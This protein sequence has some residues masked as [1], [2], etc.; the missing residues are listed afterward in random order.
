MTCITINHGNAIFSLQISSWWVH[1]HWREL[2]HIVWA[3]KWCDKNKTRIPK[4]LSVGLR[5]WKHISHE[6]Q[7]IDIWFNRQKLTAARLAAQPYW[8]T[9]SLTTAFCDIFRLHLVRKSHLINA[10]MSLIPK[11][12][13]VHRTCEDIRGSVLHVGRSS[14]HQQNSKYLPHNSGVLI[15]VVVR[16]QS[17]AEPNESHSVHIC[18]AACFAIVQFA[19]LRQRTSITLLMLVVLLAYLRSVCFIRYQRNVG[20]MQKYAL[21]SA[22]CSFIISWL[23]MRCAV[24]FA[25]RE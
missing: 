24:L 20:W 6:C 14:N 9:A 3:T 10:L 22:R 5:G 16:E 2:R 11:S 15:N 23:T 18:C 4:T 25:I 12:W 1:I 17:R 21:C 8:I 19:E 7:I 13:H